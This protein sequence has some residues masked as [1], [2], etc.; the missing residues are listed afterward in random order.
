MA[1]KRAILTVEEHFI[2][3]VSFSET[4]NTDVLFVLIIGTHILN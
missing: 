3:Q 4:S 1:I 2:N